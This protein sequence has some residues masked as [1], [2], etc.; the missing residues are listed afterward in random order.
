[1]KKSLVALAVLAASGAAMAQSSVTLYGW[2]DEYV[3]S[4]KTDSA[5]GSLTN[6]VLSSGGVNGSRWGLKGTEDLG[7]GLK[8]NFNLQQG[9]SLDTGG[10]SN[11]SGFKGSGTPGFNRQAWVGFSGD[12]GAIRLGRMTSPFDDAEGASDAVF[13]SALSPMNSVFRTTSTGTSLIPNVTVSGYDKYLSNTV[14]YLSPG[15]SGFKLYGSYS[16]GED[17]TAT[18][19]AT[20]ETS[21]AVTYADGP[22]SG[23]FAYQTLKTNVVNASDKNFLRLGAAYAFG[24]AKL[25]GTYGKAGNVGNKSSAEATEW[26]LGLDYSVS[27]AFTLSGSFAKSTDNS[28]LSTAAANGAGG[29]GE[30]ARDGVGFG[31]AYTLSKRTYLYGG[32]VTAKQTQSGSKDNQVTVFALGINSQF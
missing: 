26:Q 17:K 4:V 6:T 11:G 3:G 13:D 20:G 23:E 16:L 2:L 30:V 15:M 10:A 5:S 29:S 27:P 24:P 25:K 28:T 32:Y 19:N 7:G 8:A 9:F 31:G 12:F 21:L 18:A 1:M 22:L 14:Q